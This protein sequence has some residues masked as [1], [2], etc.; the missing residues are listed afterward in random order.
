MSHQ[1]PPA[2]AVEVVTD[3]LSEEDE[4]AQEE[5]SSPTQE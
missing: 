3:F 4:E 1:Q 2:W 5:E